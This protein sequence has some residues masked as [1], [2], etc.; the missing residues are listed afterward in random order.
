M[1]LG[2]LPQKYKFVKVSKCHHDVII[3]NICFVFWDLHLFLFF[4]GDMML[5]E[6]GQS[7]LHYLE[8]AAFHYATAVKFKP[9]NPNLHFQ[10]GQTLE[11]C[12]YATEMYDLKKK[13]IRR[14]DFLM[15][16]V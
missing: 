11:E 8:Q 5:N 4:E 14:S 2:T 1:W 7:P 13:V 12:Y 3:T 10:L 15:Q 9:Q 16:F 6:T